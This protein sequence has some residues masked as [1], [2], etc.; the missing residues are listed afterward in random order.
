MQIFFLSYVEDSKILLLSKN[1]CTNEVNDAVRSFF[2]FEQFLLMEDYNL[3][4]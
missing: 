4:E 3:N 1:S 2:L